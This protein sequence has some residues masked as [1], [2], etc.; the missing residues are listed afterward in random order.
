MV[1]M[2]VPMLFIGIGMA[3]TVSRRYAILVS[4]HR[5]LGIA[6]L[7]LAVLRLVN[8]WV[9]P[10]PPLPPDLRAL[11]R[12]AA[13]ASHHLLYAFMLILPL[14]GWAML[15]AAA[16][17]IA[18]WGGLYL[19]SIVPQDPGTYAWLRRA[20]TALA[21]LFFATI[22]LH[23]GAALFHALIRRDGVFESMAS[24][25]RTKSGSADPRP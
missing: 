6:I 24:W 17:P 20:H 15:S 18:L 22:V 2:I 7:L 12:F 21:L 9:N 16:Y 8:R 4:I 3:A 1:A 19:P 11:Q 25:R 14:V 13:V 10:P 5:P 23:F